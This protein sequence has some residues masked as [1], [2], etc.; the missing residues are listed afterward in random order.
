MWFQN[1]CN[2]VSTS[3]ESRICK[4]RF[5]W[6]RKRPQKLKSTPTSGAKSCVFVQSSLSACSTVQAKLTAESLHSWYFL[7]LA[8]YSTACWL[9]SY[10]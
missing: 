6:A 5:E 3:G 10:Q 4:R 1:A 8:K 9:S 2:E 7:N